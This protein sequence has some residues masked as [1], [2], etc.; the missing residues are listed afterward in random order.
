MADF[1]A[2]IL[3]CEKPLHHCISQFLLGWSPRQSQSINWGFKFFS[4]Q[5][6]VHD[7]RWT[8]MKHLVEIKSQ[9]PCWI[10]FLHLAQKQVQN[11]GCRFSLI[12]GFRSPNFA[13]SYTLVYWNKINQHFGFWEKKFLEME[14]QPLENESSPFC[15]TEWFHIHVKTAFVHLSVWLIGQGGRKFHRRRWLDSWQFTAQAKMCRWEGNCKFCN[16]FYFLKTWN[17]NP[18]FNWTY[19]SNV[20]ASFHRFRVA[21]F[22]KPCSE[23]L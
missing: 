22:G 18:S 20:T 14:F 17:F 19:L 15:R 23:L 6:V 1:A 11:W 16:F 4:S 5:F 7:D 12:V 21:N 9:F 13:Q 10:L 3:Q 8:F 2:V